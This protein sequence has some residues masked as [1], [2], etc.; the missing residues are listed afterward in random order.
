MFGLFKKQLKPG[1]KEYKIVEVQDTHVHGL[2]LSDA[3]NPYKGKINRMAKD[4]WILEKDEVIKTLL[5]GGRMRRLTFSK[6][7][8][9]VA[10][11][12]QPAAQNSQADE[13]QKLASL[14]EQGYLTQDEFEAKKKQILGL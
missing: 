7:S 10:D 4:G 6:G 9:P 5:I 1:Q 11:V 14:K 12:S 13:L 3:M 2:L 8:A